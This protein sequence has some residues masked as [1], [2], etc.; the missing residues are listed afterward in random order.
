MAVYAWWRATGAAGAGRRLIRALGD[1]DESLR[2]IAAMLLVKAGPR[3][4][5]LLR[6]ALRRRESLSLVLGVLGDIGGPHAEHELAPFVADADPAVARAASDALRVLRLRH[7][8]PA[9]PR[10]T[11]S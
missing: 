10:A 7:A 9:V 5:P 2:T 6:D 11:P 1:A 3:A 4:E 8:G